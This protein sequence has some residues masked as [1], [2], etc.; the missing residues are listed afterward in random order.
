M[1]VF[2][3][4]CGTPNE[5]QPGTKVICTNCTAVFEVPGGAD[6]GQAPS[7]G[8]ADTQLSAPPPTVAPP[9]TPA[10]PSWGAP[11]VNPGQPGPLYPAPTNT[12]P[13][14]HPLAITS[15]VLGLLACCIPFAASLAALI[16]G[17]IA[18]QKIDANPTAHGGRGLAMAGAILGG[19]GLAGSILLVIL[20]AIGNAH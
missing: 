19:I 11:S 15:L 4:Q 2:C 8:L 5:G 16:T 18:I 14:A 3:S 17:I 20:S 1:R 6:A 9:S 12:T 13:G 10:G 7:S